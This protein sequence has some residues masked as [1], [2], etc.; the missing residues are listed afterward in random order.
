M[1][2]KLEKAADGFVVNI[3]EEFVAETRLE[4]EGGLVEISIANGNVVL[5]PVK[6]RFLIED[7]VAAITDENMHSEIS[8][9][10]PVGKE[11]W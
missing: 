11:V 3:P 5:A 6:P 9:G 8:C 2:V 4:Q 1:Q 7:L 10:K